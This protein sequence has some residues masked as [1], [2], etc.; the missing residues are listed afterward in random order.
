MRD[1][2]MERKNRKFALNSTPIVLYTTQK[3][4]FSYRFSVEPVVKCSE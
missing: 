4:S 1:L 2:G 3:K